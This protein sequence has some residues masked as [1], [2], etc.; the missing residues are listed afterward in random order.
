MYP[1]PLRLAWHCVR[2]KP[3]KIVPTLLVSSTTINGELIM[4]TTN[5]TR[6]FH[7]CPVSAI[8]L[9]GCLYNAAAVASTALDLASQSQVNLHPEHF[10]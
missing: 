5:G 1:Q 10:L 9:A 6:A 3:T 8:R 2:N 7:A 4:T